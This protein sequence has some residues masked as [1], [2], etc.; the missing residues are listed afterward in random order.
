MNQL[1][2]LFK[3][4]SCTCAYCHHDRYQ[5]RPHGLQLVSLFCQQWHSQRHFSMSFHQRGCQQGS[6]RTLSSVRSPSSMRILHQGSLPV[7]GVRG[8]SSVTPALHDI[9]RKLQRLVL[10]HNI[11]DGDLLLV[12][13][14][15]HPAVHLLL[16]QPFGDGAFDAQEP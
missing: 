12:G 11:R 7:G 8:S 10:P 13:R 6:I 14:V 4:L 9:P 16:P 2:V 5:T 3:V 1:R 15:A